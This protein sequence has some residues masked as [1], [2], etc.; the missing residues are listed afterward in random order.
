[1][2]LPFLKSKETQKE[3]FLSLLI[4]P[5][6]IGA[7]LFEEINN[8]L[9][10]LATNEIGT[11][12]ATGELSEEELLLST[13]KVV[14]FI[15]G[16]LPPGAT[17]EKTIFSLPFSWIDEGK[18][19][20]EYLFKLKKICE[21][22]GLVPI[23]YL[24]SIEAIVHFLERS[25]G[26]PVSAVFIEVSKGETLI[27]LVRA[28][29]ILEVHSGIIEGHLVQTV[30]KLL[31]QVDS[32]D[33]LP[34][35]IILLEDKGVEGIQQEFLSNQWGKDVPFLH[36][37]Q[38]V[39]LERGFENEATI[40]GVASQME[41]EVFQNIKTQENKED[42]DEVL[43]K[44]DSSEF[45]FLKDEDVAEKKDE[46]SNIPY[47]L[48]SDKDNLDEKGKGG[49]E[50]S[51][52]YFKKEDKKD[53]QIQDLNEENIREAKLPLKTF[54]LKVFFQ[55]K[56]FK[57]PTAFLSRRFSSLK[58]SSGLKTKML[59]AAF[60]MLVVVLFFSFLYYNLILRVSITIFTDKKVQEK[61][62]DV[63]FSQNSNRENS[64]NI[65][66]FSE[67]SKGKDSQESTGK[68]ETGD[69]AHGEVTIFNKTENRK[70]FSKG[71]IL[72][73]PNDL[74]FELQGEIVIASTSPF[75][76]TLSNAK[77]KVLAKNFG[78]E[79]NL[80]SNSNWTVKGFSTSDYIGKNTDAI[81]GG[82]KKETTV[83]SENDLK[84][85]MTSVTEKLEKD[86]ISA[87]K[88]KID[89]DTE[90][91][92]KALS[93]E[94][95]TEEYTKK[96]GDESQSVGLSATIKYEI[97]KYKR[98]NLRVFIDGIL[99]KGIPSNYVFQESDSKVDLTNIKINP[100]DKSA[101]VQLD[102]RAIYVPKIQIEELKKTLKGKSKKSAQN[103]IQSINGVSDVVINLKN[104]LPLFPEVLPN[105]VKNIEIE[106]KN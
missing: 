23:G 40:N 94:V 64:I 69:K 97:G 54:F 24:I 33:V 74:E 32:V 85:L 75:S 8:K 59:I 27:Y 20:K 44:V 21:D 11:T 89:Q 101:S 73:G 30:E 51:V 104:E 39:V 4:K 31:K 47:I 50:P 2:Q 12:S 14:S 88:A 93:S 71:T 5:F 86:A 82:T 1:M 55:F 16:S 106:I 92:P 26:A 65:E 52:S 103:Q 100:K 6:K 46:T 19:K 70:T 72:V 66:I 9:F 45:G 49:E 68:K 18:I 34:P 37:P 62:A 36:V 96:E 90:V 95:M 28:S 35:K 67:E 25:E 58:D 105:N 79:F 42:Q 22:L 56:S 83:V 78:K 43:K 81:T 48:D 91:F 63:I 80:P 13:D 17:L 87:A 10:I 60:G 53:E 98:E 41:L 15:E 38:V 99:K 7:I 57:V 29:K 3:F 76:T 84:N 77:A 61:T 102:I